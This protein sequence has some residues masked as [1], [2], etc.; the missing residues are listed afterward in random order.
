[1]DA[2]VGITSYRAKPTDM[3]P[4]HARPRVQLNQRQIQQWTAEGNYVGAIFIHG[5]SRQQR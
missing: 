2:W 1:M 5:R 4:I 3:L